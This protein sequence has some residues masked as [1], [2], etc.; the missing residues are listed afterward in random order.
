M[1]LELIPSN[2]LICDRNLLKF[3]TIAEKSARCSNRHFK[4]KCI[5]DDITLYKAVQ[6]Q[7]VSNS[8]KTILDQREYDWYKE[9]KKIQTSHLEKLLEEGR[10][11]NNY[12]DRVLVKC[13]SWNGPFSS[14]EEL[15]FSLVGANVKKT[16]EILRHEITFQRITHPN[17]AIIRKE[18]YLINKQDISTLKYN[19]VILL[20]NAAIV[21]T[22]DGEIFLPTES[23]VMETLNSYEHEDNVP[24]TIQ[25]LNMIKINE[26]NA[27]IWK[28]NNEF[29][30]YIGF[31]LSTESPNLSKAEHL[32]RVLNGKDLL[33]QYPKIPDIQDTDNIQ[34]LPIEVIWEWDYSNPKKSVFEVKNCEQVNIC[35]KEYINI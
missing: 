31:I 10:K 6:I 13:K 3:S 8:L 21:E 1:D 17:D 34:I 19:L 27:I 16:R 2:N 28:E 11:I 5:R 32:T 20:S 25:D 24:V 35:F 22:N 9:Q 12:A 29:K 26:P 30:W 15:E 23:E 7:K 4:A 33:W 14:V 18:L